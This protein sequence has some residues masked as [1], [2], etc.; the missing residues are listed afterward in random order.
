MTEDFAEMNQVDQAGISY[1]LGIFS[2]GKATYL[3]TI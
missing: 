2:F 3:L 1:F